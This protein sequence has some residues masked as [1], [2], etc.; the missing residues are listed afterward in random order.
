M[1]LGLILVLSAAV[2]AQTTPASPSTPQEPTSPW[3]GRERAGRRAMRADKLAERAKR[4]DLARLNFTEAQRQQ[5][6]EIVQRHLAA[7]RAQR[8]QLMAM[9]EKRMAGALA[10]ADRAQARA[11]RT[12]LRASM[13]S[14]R[15]E[16]RNNLTNEQRAELDAL[17]EQ[18]RQQMQE[19]RERRQ[20]FR[21]TRPQP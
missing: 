14:M 17:R 13:E 6:S 1:S 2:V 5:R 4:R 10:D 18:R 19:F 11:L 15:T 7:N 20:E 3:M 8:E 21:R 12:E 9:R 16:L